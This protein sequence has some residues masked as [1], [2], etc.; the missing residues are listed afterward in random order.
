MIHYSNI[1]LY[2]DLPFDDYLAL[3]GNSNS[4]LKSE[5]NGTSPLFIQTNKIKL[6]SLV[7]ALL[8]QDD[9][10]DFADPLMNHAMKIAVEIKDTF[11][12][13]IK[14]FVPQLSY[15]ADMHYE[16]LTMKTKCR[17]D[18]MLLK[19]APVDLK[20]TAAKTDKEFVAIINHLGYKN[21]LFNYSGVSGTDTGYLMP[22]STTAG[23]CLSIVSVPK[24][25]RNSFWEGKIMKWGSVQ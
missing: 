5:V 19:K 6:G 16:G 22:Y 8:T 25:D 9:R 13:L 12:P 15:T 3:H 18:W 4:F 1:K 20:V 14:Q 11:G 2:H 7:D 21:Q 10:V 23:C 24:L 17:P